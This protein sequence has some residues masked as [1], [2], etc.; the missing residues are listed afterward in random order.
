MAVHFESDRR[1]LAWA[2]TSS[3][4]TLRISGNSNATDAAVILDSDQDLAELFLSTSDS[5]RQGLNLSS[6]AGAG[7]FRS[8]RIH[9]SDLNSGKSSFYAAIQQA[10]LTP[11][12]GIFD[13]S[14]AAHPGSALGL[15][16][17]GDAI[18]I[19]PTRIGDVNLDGIVTISDFIDL[20]SNFGRTSVIW[21]EGDLNYDGS[22]T[23]SDFIDL[24]S[25][26]GSSYAGQPVLFP[27]PTGRSRFL[28]RRPTVHPRTGID[29]TSACLPQPPLP[30]V[31]PRNRI[32][33]ITT[34]SA[35][36]C[37]NALPSSINMKTRFA[38]S[39]WFW[40]VR[41]PCPAAF[42]CV[43][44]DALIGI[45]AGLND[46]TATAS[47][48]RARSDQS[49]IQSIK[50]VPQLIR[51]LGQQNPQTGDA[52]DRQRHAAAVASSHRHFR[53]ESTS[54]PLPAPRRHLRCAAD[55]ADATAV[56]RRFG[57]DAGGISFPVR[58]FKD[59]RWSA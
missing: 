55:E 7:A 5:G 27:P 17:Q 6:P 11:G 50:M 51:R 53:F 4:A 18:F 24:A 8:L 30:P 23:I 45:D 2:P 36:N 13:S 19:R 43:S 37:G 15:V 29:F 57:A 25:N 54:T 48:S 44:A 34:F 41:L 33:S 12:D 26:F 20:S 14:L 35:I 59:V 47:R 10:R 3:T 16:I 58:I 21:Q 56:A 52:A 31:T 32:A 49:N 40:S 39:V 1:Q 42:R 22:V 9:A 46:A 38:I 28:R